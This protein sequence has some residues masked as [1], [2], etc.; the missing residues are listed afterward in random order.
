MTDAVK[1]NYIAVRR[2]ETARQTRRAVVDAAADLYLRDGFGRTTVD[3][4]AAAAGVSRKTVFRAV[5]GKVELLKLAIDWAT[6]GDDED[7]PMAERAEIADLAAQT[8]GAAIIARWAALTAA[9][10]SRVAGLSL[11]LTEAAGVDAAARHLRVQTQAQR[12]LGATAFAEFLG[13][14]RLLRADLSAQQAADLVWLYSDPAIYHRLVVD[15]NW[16][17]TEFVAWLARTGSSELLHVA[18]PAAAPATTATPTTATPTTAT[19]DRR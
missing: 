17:H 1:R 10:G 19:P 11:V 6:T 8:N 9:I 5:G 18:L 7:V 12:H 3:A 2:A 15:R 16:G 14:R 13:S 4:V